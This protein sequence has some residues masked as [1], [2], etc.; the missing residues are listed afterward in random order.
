M[1]TRAGNATAEDQPALGIIESG[2]SRCGKAKAES[3]ASGRI[4]DHL[5]SRESG[6]SL[7]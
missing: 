4:F 5:R 1:A 7:P 3:L 2:F 6:S